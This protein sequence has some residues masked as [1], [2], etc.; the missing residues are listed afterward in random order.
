LTLTISIV[1]LSTPVVFPYE[2]SEF[3]FALNIPEGFDIKVAAEG[4]KRVRFMAES[5]DHRI[6]VTDMFNLSDNNKGKVY[7]LGELN[8]ETGEFGP[9]NSRIHQRFLFED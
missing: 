8:N 7:I 3:D 2:S 6:F 1:S 4:L 9:Q 5:P